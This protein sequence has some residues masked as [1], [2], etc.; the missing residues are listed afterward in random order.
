MKR[1]PPPL[2]KP[3]FARCLKLASAAVWAGV[4]V[5]SG[6]V[7]AAPDSAALAEAEVVE[8]ALANPGLADVL[9]GRT[10]AAEARVLA[11]GRWPNPQLSY[12]REQIVGSGA[13][14]E[15]YLALSQAFDLGGYRWLAR[16]AARTRAKAQARHNESTRVDLV[17]QVREAYARALYAQERI[18]AV[19]RWRHRVQAA[20]TMAAERVSAGDAP[21]LHVERLR[22]E[23]QIVDVQI[24]RA[25]AELVEA[26][27]T[28]R[29]LMASD[30]GVDPPALAGPLLPAGSDSAGSD[31]AGSDSADGSVVDSPQL[32]ALSTE[33]E[34]AQ[35]GLR[36]SR[37]A[38][39]PP[40][41][42]SLGYKAVD[43]PAGA[44]RQHGFTA[45]V[46]V[47][48]PLGNRG[49]VERR[50][51]QARVTTVRGKAAVARTRLEA[52][53]A[54]LRSRRSILMAGVASGGAGSTTDLS[55][56]AELAYQGGEIGAMELLDAHRSAFATQLAV[57]DL[58]FEIRQVR[59][60]QDR[61]HGKTTP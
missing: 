47:P 49:Q 5:Y 4:V 56:L 19:E 33:M 12:T 61:I 8:R 27:G 42:V 9:T 58:S 17:A 6:P 26:W 41:S 60:D 24:A 53:D 7:G 37:R 46:T 35:I 2:K 39:V 22:R 48:I 54:E 55:E 51:A 52:R 14:G 1:T 23:L 21:R 20:V 29:T 44:V 30:R 3:I 18:A 36:A 50:K 11:A 25:R 31:S 45:G 10:G 28:V 57:L 59:I 43:P 40:V 32:Q 15:D 34:A 38:A 16:K 13:N